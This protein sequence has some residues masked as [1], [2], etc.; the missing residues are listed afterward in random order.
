MASYYNL[1][2]LKVL[3][4]ED[5]PNM[6]FLILQ[7]MRALGIREVK[8]AEDGADALEALKLETFDLVITDW[9]MAP[10]NGIELARLVRTASDSRNPFVPIIMLTAH[11]ELSN[12][13]EA[14]DSGID[15]FLAKPISAKSLY[16][17]IVSVIEKRRQF[18][19]TQR[20]FGPDRRRRVDVSSDFDSPDRRHDAEMIDCSV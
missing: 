14:R 6:R 2:N 7:I 3:I 12:V 11:T 5:N 1:K 9:E 20:F 17:K 15:E 19:R 4:V 10:I 16:A 18:V 13:V 8:E